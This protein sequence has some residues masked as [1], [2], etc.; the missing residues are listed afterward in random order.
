MVLHRSV[1][2]ANTTTPSP[3]IPDM[4]S[5]Q[6]QN[7]MLTLPG[8]LC[9][10]HLLPLSSDELWDLQGSG[11]LLS[12]VPTR[13]SRAVPLVTTVLTTTTALDP[14]EWGMRGTTQKA[15]PTGLR[16]LLGCEAPH[17]GRC[18][19][20]HATLALGS[21]HDVSVYALAQLP[22]RL[23]RSHTESKGRPA[24]APLSLSS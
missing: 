12:L 3:P 14:R 13:A 17:R 8:K 10:W 22:L 5:L 1:V 4:H 7:K 6:G 15:A 11:M 9:I 16:W 24:L 19:Q 21:G 2:E 20:D 23:R 18:P